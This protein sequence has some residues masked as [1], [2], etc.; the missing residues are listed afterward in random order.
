MAFKDPKDPNHIYISSL[1]FAESI[2]IT[3]LRGVFSL[4]QKFNMPQYDDSDEH[5]QIVIGPSRRDN[6]IIEDTVKPKII[7]TR[8]PVQINS[9][10]GVGGSGIGG[11]NPMTGAHQTASLRRGSVAI[12]CYSRV[13][14]E[15]DDLAEYCAEAI[16][17]F[18]SI[19]QVH[20]F[21]SIRA[22]Q[23][24]SRAIVIS[25]AKDELFV[26]PIV[27]EYDISKVMNHSYV[28][29]VKLR[30][31]VQKVIFTPKPETVLESIVKKKE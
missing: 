29:V 16:N 9:Q 21:L 26:V 13:E 19:L 11:R 2:I 17:N 6:G 28:D 4:G 27:I 25:G 3:F 7:V 23:I 12:S 5:T 14:L 1:R 10:L 20:G 18:K 15:A 31:V 24:G 30:E 22:S 8:G